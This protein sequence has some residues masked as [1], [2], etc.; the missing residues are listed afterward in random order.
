MFELTKKMLLTGIGLAATSKEKLQEL[1]KEL[2][3]KGKLSEEEGKEL[4]DQLSNKWEEAGKQ[5]ETR[6]EELV[7]TAL[8]KLD[9]PSKSDLAKLTA[10]L[11]RLEKTERNADS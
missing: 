4:L 2:A 5:L 11:E 9:M 7:K 8:E 1:A 3:E 10:R 6:I